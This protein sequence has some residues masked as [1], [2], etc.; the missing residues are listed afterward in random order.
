MAQIMT[1]MLIDP[2]SDEQPRSGERVRLSD[3]QTP[4]VRPFGE[5]YNG[6]SKVGRRWDPEN[7]DY[8]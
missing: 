2:L 5:A 1:V 7:E 4:E 3:S 8:R 6:R